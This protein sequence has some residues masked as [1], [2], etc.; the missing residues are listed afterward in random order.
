VSDRDAGNADWEP[1]GQRIPPLPADEWD[2]RVREIL[3]PTGTRVARLEG[4]EAAPPARPLHILTTLAHHP[5]L[6]ESFIGFAST[7]TLR[8]RLTRRDAELASLRASWNCGSDFEWG[9]H[10]LYA[11]GA[12]LSEAEIR[13]VAA[14]AEAAGW[15]EKEAALLRAADEL[16]REQ[17]ILEPTWEVLAQHLAPDQLIELLFTVGQYTTLS[18]IT[19]ALRIPLEPHLEGLPERP[20]G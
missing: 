7:L 18:R 5:V 13:R 12:G 14:G 9:H 4:D 1:T 6:L 3:A 16:H 10:R 8:G 17:T 19:N 11:L 20:P 15:S 2:A